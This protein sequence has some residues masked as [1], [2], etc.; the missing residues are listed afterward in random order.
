MLLG[1]LAVLAL[2]ILIIVHEWGHYT[3]ARLCKMRVDRFAIGFGPALIRR[4][5][6]DTMF[7]V[8]VVPLGGYVQIAGLNPEDEAIDHDDPRAYPNRPAW[9]RFLTIA[10]GSTVNY[11]F[12]V[13]LLLGLNWILGIPGTMAGRVLPNKPAAAAGMMDND[14]IVRIDGRSIVDPSQ[15]QQLIGRAQGRPVILDVLRKGESQTRALTVTP[16]QDDGVWR[17]GIEL[18]ITETRQRLGFVA[19]LGQ[20]LH[21]PLTLTWMNLKA[22]GDM[23]RGKQKPDFKSP[24]YIVRI[25]K[26]QL[27]L[28]A[29][30]GL[31]F[32]AMIS[33]LLGFFNLLPLPALDGGR[34]VFLGWELVTRRPVNQRVEQIVHL[35]G[36]ILL[37]GLLLL[38]VVKDLRDWIFGH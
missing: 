20:A 14:Q 24:I 19:A 5:W 17:I 36:M 30:K 37:L 27:G 8:G 2:G 13:I 12:A 7:Q 28:G 38:L 34:L 1:L 33:T 35:V 21:E 16:L 11:I 6:G 15:V 23:F 18:T 9:Q 25:M 32:V 26:E 4:Q 10:A 3:V 29:A 22:F 31:Q